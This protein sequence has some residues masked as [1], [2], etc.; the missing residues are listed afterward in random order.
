[1]TSNNENS[2]DSMDSDSVGAVRDDNSVH[3]SDGVANGMNCR[4]PLGR[5]ASVDIIRRSD[6]EEEVE[7]DGSRSQEKE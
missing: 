7:L 4:R 5:A 1:M 6:F 3:Y 2:S